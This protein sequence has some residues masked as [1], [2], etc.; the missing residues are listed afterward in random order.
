MQI[1]VLTN[2]TGL[3]MTLMGQAIKSLRETVKDQQFGFDT[4]RKALDFEK[5]VNNL[6]Y[7][8]LKAVYSPSEEDLKEE[9]ITLEKTEDGGSLSTTGELTEE[10]KRQELAK[11]LFDDNTKPQLEKMAEDMKLEGWEQLNKQPLAE[12]IAAHTEL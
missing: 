1:V 8:G 6:G 4:C 7:S 10:Q 9:G 12:L 11:K 2:R 3:Q 5:A